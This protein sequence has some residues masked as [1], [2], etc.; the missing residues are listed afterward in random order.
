[1]NM[2]RK[3]FEVVGQQ[4]DADAH[5]LNCA[6]SIYGPEVYEIDFQAEDREG[7]PVHPIFLGDEGIDF[8]GDCGA[9]LRD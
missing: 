1:M 4:Y 2:Y 8:C 7:N 6:E 3:S 9:N 5:C